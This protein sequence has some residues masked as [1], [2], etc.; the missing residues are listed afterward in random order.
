MGST[1]A[2]CGGVVVVA[3]ESQGVLMAKPRA[4]SSRVKFIQSAVKHPGLE[5]AKA[6]KAGMGVQEYARKHAGDSGKAG[7]RARFAMNMKKI[8]N[9]HAKS[10]SDGD[11]GY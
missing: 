2:L 7:Q 11:E 5:T 1:G 3:D 8:A 10:D 6:K 4:S 9:R